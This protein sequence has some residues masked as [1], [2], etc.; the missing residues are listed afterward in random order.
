[1]VDTQSLIWHLFESSKLSAAAST[2]LIA[3]ETDT[4]SSIYLSVIS[5]VE[6]VYL[7]EKNKFPVTI[8]DRTI[9]AVDDPETCL[10][11]LPA[12]RTMLAALR[13]IPRSEVPDLPDRL[14][15]ATA[16][17][18]GLPLVTSDSEIIASRTITIW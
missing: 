15:A 8:L 12:D 17:S 9:L 7:V 5:L 2:A 1:M 3:A 4:R 10:E 11:V 6:I 13:E 18:R 14:I 16:R